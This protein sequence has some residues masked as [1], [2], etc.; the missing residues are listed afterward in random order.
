MTHRRSHA[1]AR[2][3]STTISVAL[4]LMPHA[5]N[6]EMTVMRAQRRSLT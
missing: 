5:S 2:Q 4:K 1:S 6:I 3:R